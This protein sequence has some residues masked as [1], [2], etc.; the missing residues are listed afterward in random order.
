MRTAATLAAIL[1]LPCGLFA[2][3]DIR[4]PLNIKI[5]AP[6]VEQEA[7]CAAVTPAA[8]AASS[9]YDTSVYHLKHVHARQIIPAVQRAICK[10]ATE[11]AGDHATHAVVSVAFMPTTSDD[12]LVTVC[13][14]EHAAL[15]KEAVAECDVAKQYAVKVQLF[16]VTAS[17]ETVPVGSPSVIVGHEGSV[18]CKSDSHGPIT[19]SLQVRDSVADAADATLKAPVATDSS[20]E[21]NCSGPDCGQPCVATKGACPVAC[22]GQASET[23][24]CPNC[25]ESVSI[26]D[27]CGTCGLTCDVVTIAGSGCKCGESCK[28]KG[29]CKCGKSVATAGACPVSCSGQASETCSCP[30][31]QGTAST[32]AQS[33]TCSGIC[34]VTVTSTSDCKCGTSSKC[35]GDCSCGSKDEVTETS[36][37]TSGSVCENSIEAHSHSAEFT[38]DEYRTLV[39]IL[40]THWV[41]EHQERTNGVALDD[42][43]P[44]AGTCC[45]GA[46]TCPTERDNAIANFLGHHANRHVEFEVQLGCRAPASSCTCPSCAGHACTQSN[47]CPASVVLGTP[48]DE[49]LFIRKNWIYTTGNEGDND[50]VAVAHVTDC[51]KSECPFSSEPGSA[52]QPALLTLSPMKDGSPGFGIFISPEW[53]AELSKKYQGRPLSEIFEVHNGQDAGAVALR[54]LFAVISKPESDAANFRHRNVIVF[55][56]PD[57]TRAFDGKCEANSA[58]C[59]SC[60]NCHDSLRAL[61]EDVLQSP[62]LQSVNQAGHV[63]YDESVAKSPKELPSFSHSKI[64]TTV[65]TYPLHDLILLDGAERPVFD[66]CT[67][68]DHIQAAVAPESWA[69]PSV[70]IQLDQQKMSLVI[71]QTPEVHKKIDAHLHELRRLQVKRL[72]KMIEQISTES[73]D[74]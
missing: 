52:E 15:V 71:R 64:E 23:G 46:E 24:I 32:S 49:G 31:C 69:H 43:A 30:N 65:V 42:A 53:Q 74:D 45:P 17:G 25:K 61:L 10:H 39:R 9:K 33:G 35:T 67:F 5:A 73:E 18:E 7:E 70:S 28:C 72:C 16:E 60:A 21:A 58:S 47:Q 48:A 55:D 26:G 66:T 34:E 2:D 68:I 3:D 59:G 50:D 54:G 8:A 57:H 19:V 63:E 44:S 37:E 1:L 4:T 56:L 29:T 41:R 20:E 40:L 51:G 22:S 62:I 27:Q 6:A 11:A 38:T 36:S 12:T 13:R 14:H